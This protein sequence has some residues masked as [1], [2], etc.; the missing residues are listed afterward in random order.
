M[1]VDDILKQK[2]AAT[3]QAAAQ[4]LAQR[5]QAQAAKNQQLKQEQ[6]QEFAAKQQALQETAAA[7]REKQQEQMAEAPKIAAQIQ[8]SQVVKPQTW[9]FQPFH[10]M[11]APDPFK[12]KQ[13]MPGARPP[14]TGDP[15]L[16]NSGG[17]LQG[18]VK[19]LQGGGGNANG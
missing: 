14:S 19:A 2:L 8:D 9:Q 4:G 5:Q 3:Q 17:N 10:P 18:M 1:A 12:L 13:P 7:L 16:P 15:L 6:E 11:Q